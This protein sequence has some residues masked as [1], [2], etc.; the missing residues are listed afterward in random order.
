MATTSSNNNRNEPE[1][2]IFR[3]LQTINDEYDHPFTPQQVDNIVK[4]IAA[5]EF[6]RRIRIRA[7]IAVQHVYNHIPRFVAYGYLNQMLEKLGQN[8]PLSIIENHV[9]FFTFLIRELK[10]YFDGALWLVQ[11]ELFVLENEKFVKDVE[12]TEEFVKEIF[13]DRLKGIQEEKKQSLVELRVVNALSNCS[14]EEDQEMSNDALIEYLVYSDAIKCVFEKEIKDVED[15]IR[16]VRSDMKPVLEFEAKHNLNCL[17]FDIFSPSIVRK[18]VKSSTSTDD[19]FA[20]LDQGTSNGSR[21]CLDK[22]AGYLEGTSEGT[23]ERLKKFN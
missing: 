10:G 17:E 20:W 9:E 14:L 16:A 13:Q 3:E 12:A 19:E 2:S 18:I 5:D 11:L 6:D 15:M 8:S 7:D 1:S 22:K 4:F 21:L 23:E